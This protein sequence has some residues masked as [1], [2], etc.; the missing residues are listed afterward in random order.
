MGREDNI[1]HDMVTRYHP[2]T[3]EKKLLNQ[4]DPF[5]DLL[6]HF[7]MTPSGDRQSLVDLYLRKR[8]SIY[9]ASFKRPLRQP[10]I[11]RDMEILLPPWRKGQQGP[12]KYPQ[13]I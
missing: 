1:S 4:D 2:L 10:N 11:S 9:P 3:N 13:V 5:A 7:L 12:W 8:V 6:F